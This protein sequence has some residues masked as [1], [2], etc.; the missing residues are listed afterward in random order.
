MK[1]EHQRDNQRSRVSGALNMY[2]ART[3]CPPEREA[4]K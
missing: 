2:G 1:F 4:R 3:S